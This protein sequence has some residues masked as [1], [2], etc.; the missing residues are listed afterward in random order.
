MPEQAK[1]GNMSN[2]FPVSALSRV[3]SLLEEVGAEKAAAAK[4]GSDGGTELGHSGSAAKD[5]GGYKGPSSHPSAKADGNVQSA[6]IGERFRENSADMKDKHTLANVDQISGDGG[7]QDSK[8]LNI[9]TQQS[10]TGEDP[11]SED[12][13]KSTKE[14][15]GTSHPA[16]ADEQGKKYASMGKQALTKLA[17]DKMN[18]VLADMA[19]GYHNK[20]AAFTAIP[21][22][23]ATPAQKTAADNAGIAAQAGYDLAGAVAAQQPDLEKQAAFQE[24]A[25]GFIKQA[26]EDAEEVATFL[27][28]YSAERT[29]LAE[30]PMPDMMGGGGGPPPGPG[31][32]EGMGGG[33]PGG[34]GG[35]PEGGMPPEMGGGAPPPGPM[36]GGEMGGGGGGPGGPGGG[37]HEQA[38]MELANAL[39]E[40]GISPDELIAAMQGGGA[41]GGMGGGGPGGPGGGAPEGMGGGGGG[42]PSPGGEGGEG[43]PEG[44]GGEPEPEPEGEKAGAARLTKSQ[45]QQVIK[46][47]SA[48]KDMQRKGKIRVKEAKPGSKT[49]VDRDEMKNF[50]NEV[51]RR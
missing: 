2:T 41:G 17:Y 7:S 35:G 9:G 14:D 31:G 34:M 30:G 27:S 43:G 11:K 39:M 15:P 3:T 37:G 18:E 48:V 4:Q 10:A 36:P 49:R 22:S 25:E 26:L 19:N 5:P 51:C 24:A 45:R 38:L 23:K 47:A 6:P 28:N 8:Q 33:M 50:L 40:A 46:M 16:N 1:E 42:L 12:N 21:A 32:P 20:K 44:D 29:K 13:F